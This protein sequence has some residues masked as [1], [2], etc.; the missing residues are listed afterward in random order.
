MDH[1]PAWQMLGEVPPRG[2]ASRE[3]LNLDG[4]CRRPG[5]I[6]RRLRGQFLEL[7]FEL[8]EK[9]AAAF[10]A[11]AE[12]LPPHLG[13]DQLKMRDHHLGP[14]QLG[15]RLDQRRL[16]RVLVVRKMI[17]CPH[18]RNCITMQRDS[19]IKSAP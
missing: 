15:A 2:C 18:K 16:Q 1:A 9:P 6:L 12:H 13:N 19:Q 3:A 7:Q 5:R 8:I 4:C 17:G 10:R 14:G 11:R